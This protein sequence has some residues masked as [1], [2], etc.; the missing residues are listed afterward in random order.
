MKKTI[1]LFALL[2]VAALAH[3]EKVVLSYSVTASGTNRAVTAITG[4]TAGVTNYAVLAGAVITRPAG[5]R[6]TVTVYGHGTGADAALS[7]SVSMVN[8]STS[9]VSAVYFVPQKTVGNVPGSVLVCGTNG[10]FA[11]D[12]AN[13]STNVWGVQFFIDR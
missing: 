10:W 4:A 8:A 6:A 5:G 9:Q 12:Q 13:T 7:D 2:S 3:A 11:I 1:F